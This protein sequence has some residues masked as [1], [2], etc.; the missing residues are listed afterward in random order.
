MPCKFTAICCRAGTDC[1][2]VCAYRFGDEVK[3][4]KKKKREKKNFTPELTETPAVLTFL[5]LF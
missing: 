5:C 1:L 4:K 3:K 2:S